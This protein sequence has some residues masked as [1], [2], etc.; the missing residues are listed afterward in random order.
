MSHCITMYLKHCI[1]VYL[2]HLVDTP[3]M[4]IPPILPKS[5]L[6]HSEKA[7][8]ERLTYLGLKSIRRTKAE[9]AGAEMRLHA[10]VSKGMKKRK[11]PSDPTKDGLAPPPYQKAKAVFPLC[12]RDGENSWP[13]C[14]SH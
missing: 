14:A 6:D 13:D 12:C 11:L 7:L 2:K 1:T 10:G 3:D 8:G 5:V 9:R 4:R